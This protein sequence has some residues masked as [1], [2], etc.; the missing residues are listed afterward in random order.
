MRLRPMF[1]AFLTGVLVCGAP[2]GTASAQTTSAKKTPPAQTDPNKPATRVAGS[3]GNWTLLCGKEGD[4]KTA[5]ERCSLVLPLIEKKTQKLI[6]RVI[7]VYGP[8]GRL[9]LRVDG[10]TGVALQR[11]VQLATDS[12]KVY[13]MPYQTC[14]PMGCK[15]LYLVP[16]EM[17][18]DLL[19]SKKGTIV[20]YALNGKQIQTVAEFDG[21]ALGLEALD[22]KR[23][24]IV[25]NN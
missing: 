13:T 11:G 14:L 25:K 12:E 15:A 18:Q 9:V 24:A 17:R 3:Y 21:L 7:L 19:N 20:V 8:K 6:F 10:P 4:P 22:K 16:D 2:L 1:L 23:T 5:E